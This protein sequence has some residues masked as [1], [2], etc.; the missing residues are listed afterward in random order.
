M[1]FKVKNINLNIYYKYLSLLICDRSSG[2]FE[3]LDQLRCKIRFTFIFKINIFSL[4][5]NNFMF[6]SKLQF[7]PKI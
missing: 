6:L 7:S 4:K 3:K 1:K 5:Q 2:I